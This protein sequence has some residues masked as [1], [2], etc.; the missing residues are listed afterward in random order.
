MWIVSDHKANCLHFCSTIITATAETIS[1]II[2]Q[3]F[4]RRLINKIIYYYILFPN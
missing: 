2:D 3:L 1:E 4:D